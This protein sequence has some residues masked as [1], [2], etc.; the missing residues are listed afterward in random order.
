LAYSTNYLVHPW[1]KRGQRLSLAVLRLT[2]FEQRVDEKLNHCSAVAG[3]W[4]AMGLRHPRPILLSRVSGEKITVHA[5]RRELR[6]QF[7]ERGTGTFCFL[8]VRGQA[9]DVVTVSFNLE[10]EM[11]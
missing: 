11:M 8:R 9:V 10:L 6:R 2:L 4:D 1:A 7:F 5:L 3:G